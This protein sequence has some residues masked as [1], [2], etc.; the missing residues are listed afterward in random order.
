VLVRYTIS[1]D[2]NLDGAVGFPD[3]V[4]V[5]QNYGTASGATW[6]RG[7][8]NYDGA[9]GFADLVAL[10]QSYG[11]ALPSEAIPGAT[12]DFQADMAAAFSGAVPEPSGMVFVAGLSALGAMRRRRRNR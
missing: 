6:S 3:L 12:P 4:R 11:A 1:G 2:A 7:D 8:F 5:A 9:V 10:A